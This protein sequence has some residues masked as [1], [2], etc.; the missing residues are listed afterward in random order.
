MQGKTI[1]VGGGM[2]G[3]A[4]AMRLLQA[5]Q[6]FTLIT[7]DLGGRIRYSPEAGVNF[8]AYFVMGN[9]AHARQLVRRGRWIN[10]ADVRF[11][12][13]AREHFT[14]F[15]LHSLGLLGEFL[16]FYAALGEFSRHYERFKRGCLTVSHRE[17]LAA[18]P[19][20]ATIYAT[21]A[22][23]FIRQRR[24][25][26]VAA[27]YVGKFAYACT[28]ADP[29][30]MTALDFL[31]VSM[32]LMV[33]IH[34]LEFDPQALAA[35]LGTH[36]VKDTITGIENRAGRHILKGKSGMTY[37]AD[38]L[39]LA[40]PAAVT[41]ELLDLGEIRGASQIYVYHLKGELKPVYR[42]NA[43]NLFPP[44][45]PMM[46]T[47]RQFDGTYLVYGSR[48]EIDL[49]AVCERYEL[50]DTCG[51]EKAMYVYGKAH[52]EQE[53]G[54]GVYVAGDH[55]GLGLEPAAISGLYAANRILAKTAKQDSK[56]GH[57]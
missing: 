52:M 19:Y 43:I 8:G 36:L 45:G 42:R 54:E 17:A 30:N 31:N 48:K 50:L 5:G 40:T 2:A 16:R 47:A 41:Q 49:N 46:L 33:P 44:D 10:P 24:F 53:Y 7:D 25:E 4:C 12:N 27:D 9:Y 51:W 56:K 29:Q 37:S 18:D 32:S 15:S 39:V 6:D 3:I 57:A 23:E 26:K 38:N 11:H 1:I 21:P 14:A 55:N 22:P 20:M 13:G 28:G 34:Q 35:K